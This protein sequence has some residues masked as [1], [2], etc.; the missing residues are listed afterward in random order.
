M[1]ESTTDW[2]R[3]DDTILRAYRAGR[4]PK[5]LDGASQCAK[6]VEDYV[7]VLESYAAGRS[8]E[9]IAANEGWDEHAVRSVIRIAGRLVR[10]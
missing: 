9:D 5:Y 3:I 8:A 6:V 7:V 1:D 4:L 10:N 2:D